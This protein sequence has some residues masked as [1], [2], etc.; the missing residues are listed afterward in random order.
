[1][2]GSVNLDNRSLFFNYEVVTFV[3]TGNI[4]EEVE[5]WMNGLMSH[6]STKLSVPSKVREALENIM[7]V[8]AP[9]L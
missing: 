8:F 5:R 2:L 6:A 3:Y 7:K 4:I 9:V 1:M